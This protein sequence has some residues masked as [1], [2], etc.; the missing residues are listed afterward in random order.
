MKSSIEKPLN[1]DIER[2]VDI[3]KLGLIML[4]CAIGSFENFEQSGYIF[5]NLKYV[6]TEKG[7]KQVE[8]DNVCC[9]IHSEQYLLDLN[10]NNSLD[11]ERVLKGSEDRFISYIKLIKDRF[12]IHFITF[13][14]NSLK[15]SHQKRA[16]L[17][18]LLNSNFV[19]APHNNENKT[20]K[21]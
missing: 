2:S 21:I 3:F 8:R 4:N 19:I 7:Q 11:A 1:L 12:S 10:H 18:D 15:L 20:V 13:L 9:L 5:E 6:F 17:N 14:C 16:N